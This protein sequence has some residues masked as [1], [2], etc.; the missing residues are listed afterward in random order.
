MGRSFDFVHRKALLDKHKLLAPKLSLRLPRNVTLRGVKRVPLTTHFRSC[1]RGLEESCE[2]GI[3]P[4]IGRSTAQ[5]AQDMGCAVRLAS[6]GVSVVLCSL[7]WLLAGEETAASGQISESEQRRLEIQRKSEPLY[8][9]ACPLP[10]APYPSSA[11]VLLLAHLQSFTLST[12]ALHPLTPFHCNHATP[13]KIAGT[14]C[15][16]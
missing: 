12:V 8:P 9:S 6:F 2:G 3:T 4:N 11:S 10:P 16:H 15:R 5:S 7:L 13:C 14:N 1:G